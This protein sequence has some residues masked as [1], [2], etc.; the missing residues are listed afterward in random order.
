MTEMETIR[1]NL[2]ATHT[3]S[4]SQ[5]LDAVLDLG[6]RSGGL[7]GEL[8][9]DGIVLR[10]ASSADVLGVP[11]AQSAFRIM[12]AGLCGRA[13]ELTGKKLSPYR[14]ES[15]FS[16]KDN[17]VRLTVYNELRDMHF[18]L[19]MKAANTASQPIAAKR[20]SG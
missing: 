7:H 8:G 19:E 9:V 16:W 18:D 10:G 12:L 17:R 2:S 4:L 11:R 3:G 15:E 1:T 20:G 13:E 14:N 6:C 5:V